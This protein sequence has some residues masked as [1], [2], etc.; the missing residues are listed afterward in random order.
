[1]INKTKNYSLENKFTLE[2]FALLKNYHF[3]KILIKVEESKMNETFHLILSDRK[4]LAIE[5]EVIKK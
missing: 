3:S 2:R 4:W 5:Q 1:M